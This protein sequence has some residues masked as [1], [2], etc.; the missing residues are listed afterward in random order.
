MNATLY[1]RQEAT[2]RAVPIRVEWPY[3]RFLWAEGNFSCDCN[4]AIF[5][6]AQ[7]GLPEPEDLPCGEIAYTIS[8]VMDDGSQPESFE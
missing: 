2:G 1:L 4:R 8:V 5:W 3:E 7:L 6:H